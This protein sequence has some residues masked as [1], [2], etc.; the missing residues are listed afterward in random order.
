MNR[1][2]Y[3]ATVPCLRRNF[4]LKVS[5]RQ[6]LRED[7][8]KLLQK[9]VFGDSFLTY[10]RCLKIWGRMPTL[11]EEDAREDDSDA[12]LPGEE[13]EYDAEFGG[14]FVTD[15]PDGSAEEVEQVWSSLAVVIQKCK[16]ITDLIW[17][18]RNQL[19]PC[20]LHALD[21]CHPS[22][23]LDLRTFR[24]RS[25]RDP[26]TNSHELD[27]IQSRHLHS[28]SVKTVRRD[29]DGKV[30]YNMDAIFL[31]AALA[32]NLRHLNIVTPLPGASPQLL[33]A[34]RGGD[35]QRVPW[36]GFVPPLHATG[37]GALY[38]LAYVGLRGLS[39][40]HIQS[41]PTY[42]CLSQLRYLNLGV[43]SDPR[44][45]ETLAQNVKLTSLIRFYV[46]LEPTRNNQRS[47]IYELGS[48]LERLQPLEEI[49]LAG[50]L[51]TSI[52]DKAIERHGQTL[53]RLAINPYQDMYG[54]K[55]WLDAI[56][57][58]EIRKMETDCPRLGHLK[59][60]IPYSTAAGAS[61][62]SL[63]CPNVRH[64]RELT[65]SIGRSEKG[66]SPSQVAQRIWNLIDKTQTVR[67]S[68]LVIVDFEACL[69]LP[70]CLEI[71][72]LIDY[73]N[74]CEKVHGGR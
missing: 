19:P 4:A 58:D 16:Y 39:L 67:L 73:C 41:W 21:Q 37:R 57:P 47:L 53:H 27:L 22:C 62:I 30:D 64:L 11:A 45:L 72:M 38:S 7:T 69:P 52:F 46:C 29:S 56:G 1:A 55:I 2:C 26:V 61:D 12:E 74:P 20:L 10:V 13:E 59:I 32:P 5:A 14:V 36:K 31:V 71:L 68:R 65:L 3:R 50:S 44:V 34:L 28:I 48:V 60:S 66:A 33:R 17:V 9:G 8:A 6:K 42:V 23:R 24:L 63:F 49:G 15:L 40:E 54:P 51:S 25:L 35:T 70:R 18:C 43:V